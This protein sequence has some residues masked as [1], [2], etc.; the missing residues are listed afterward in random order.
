MLSDFGQ[1]G[2]AA[3]NADFQVQG[4]PDI[5]WAAKCQ[6]CHMPDVVGA[7]SFMNGTPVRPTDSMEHP[8]SGQPLHDMTGGN[9]WISHI[10]ASLDPDGP[11]YDAVNAQILNQG[12]DVLTLDLTAGQ[13][14]SQ[15]G[16][17]LKAGADRAKEQLRRAATIKDLAQLPGTGEITFKVQN[18]TGHKLISGFPEGRRMFIN[19]KAYAEDVL[20]HEINPYDAAVGTLKGLPNANS[21]PQLAAHEAYAD[22]L[23]YEMHPKVI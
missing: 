4:A 22:E 7:A 14:P 20:I 6:D 8:A 21:S 10:L 16:D 19:I 18:N 11:V 12:P 23:V 17:A 15:N 9:M 3:T 13:V 5:L 1:Q 2:G